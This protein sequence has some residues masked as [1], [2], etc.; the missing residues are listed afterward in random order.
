MLLSVD[1][2]TGEVLT[3]GVV[4][5]ADASRF[6]YTL[7]GSRSGRIGLPSIMPTICPAT[8]W[9]VHE[10]ESAAPW[11]THAEF[12]IG[13]GVVTGPAPKSGAL[14]VWRAVNTAVQSPLKPVICMSQ[15]LL[16]R[17]SMCHALE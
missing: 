1:A 6:T 4:L 2:F 12:L 9:S 15:A 13:R 11:R 10:P 3:V 14:P 7:I 17:S 8:I 16:S 5:P